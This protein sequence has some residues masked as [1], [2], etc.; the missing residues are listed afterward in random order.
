M[1]YKTITFEEKE[2]G[3]GL[4]VLNR[5]ER[6]NAANVE[7]LDD[8]Y[9][10]F[11]NLRKHPEIRVLILT[12]AGRG[13]CSGADLK[14]DRLATEE[15]IRVFSSASI[16]L[17]TVQKRYAGVIV[18]MKRLA[19]P[20]IAAVNGPASGIGLCM[21]LASDIIIANSKASFTASFINLGLSGGEL[22]TT[23][24]LP[25]MVGIARASEILMTGRT[26]YAEEA[27]KIGLIS[28]LVHDEDLMNS[29]WETAKNLVSK[30]PLGLR[31]TKEALK[32]NLDVN[33]LETAIEIENRNQS[34]C[35][36]TPEFFEA[37]K[38]FVQSRDKGD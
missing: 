4:I 33:S 18:E 31:L 34:I 14:D 11:D 19:Q 27:D 30:T 5:P 38:A 7:M 8:F 20:I 25:R 10:L 17:E 3:I 28:R 1:E 35:C 21:V 13:F 32:Q 37:I 24:F 29:A 36:C 2:P 16:H 26:V 22:G 6:L 23:Y 12:G 15:G 9:A